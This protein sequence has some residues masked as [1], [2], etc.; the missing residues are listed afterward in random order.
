MNQY[1]IGLKYLQSVIISLSA[2]FAS[3]GSAAFLDVGITPG[4]VA[5]G[6]DARLGYTVTQINNLFALKT[7][8]LQFGNTGSFTPTQPNDPATKLYVDN[9][10]AKRLVSGSTPIGTLTSGG[11]KYTISF[12]T[13]L[14]SASY[15][16]H[17]TPT[18]STGSNP[19]GISC[20]VTNKTTVGFDV[21]IY[22]A[23]TV[24]SN[25]S[26]DWIIFGS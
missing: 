26:L 17:V 7:T 1:R 5:A 18:I 12:G 14:G 3:L 19:G 2:S 11:A 6:D 16:A 15:I 4:T 21:W 24:P 10:A 13:T 22:P 25:I 20:T 9:S 23:A 8:V